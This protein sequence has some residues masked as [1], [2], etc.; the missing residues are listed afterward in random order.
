MACFI[1]LREAAMEKQNITLTLPK[2]VLKRVK[3]M[4]AERGTSVSALMER[5]LQDHL[6]RHEGYEQAHQRQSALLTKGF[7]LG[8]KGKRTWRREELHER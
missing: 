1:D 4:A 5:L 7:D 6:A 3:V 8:T 2:D